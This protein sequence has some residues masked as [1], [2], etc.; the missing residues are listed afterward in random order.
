[1]KKSR[2]N[3]TQIIAILQKA[4]P[5]VPVK[6]FLRKH[7]ISGAVNGSWNPMTVREPGVFPTCLHGAFP[8]RPS[9]NRI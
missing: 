4:Y 5:G 7:G 2:F 1:M 6:D 9:D 8:P 3:K